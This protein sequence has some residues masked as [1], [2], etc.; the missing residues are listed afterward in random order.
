MLVDVNVCMKEDCISITG[1]RDDGEECVYTIMIVKG[2]AFS[3]LDR[4]SSARQ[5]SISHK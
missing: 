4:R 3:G 1:R 2:W 5:V